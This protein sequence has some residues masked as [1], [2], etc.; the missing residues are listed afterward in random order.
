VLRDLGRPAEAVEDALERLK[1]WP[2]SAE[3]LCAVAGELAQAAAVVGHGQEV[4]SAD[5]ADERHR[6][7]RQA[8]ALLREAVRHGFRDAEQLRRDADLA[9]LRDEDDFRALLAELEQTPA[10]P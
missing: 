10:R 3:E 5:E 6:Y 1:V 7:A 2:D 8:V 4:L 9:P